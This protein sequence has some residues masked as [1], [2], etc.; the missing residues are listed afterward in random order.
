MTWS[1]VST[2]VLPSARPRLRSRL[3]WRLRRGGCRGPRRRR[4]RSAP[5]PG[6]SCAPW[7]GLAS[8]GLAALPVRLA[9]LLRSCSVRPVLAVLPLLPV[10]LTVL[11]GPLAGGRAAAVLTGCRSV[12]VELLGPVASR[13]RVLGSAVLLGA[14]RA[15]GTAVRLAPSRGVGTACSVALS[16]WSCELTPRGRR[17]RPTRPRARTR[18]AALR[19]GGRRGARGAADLARLDGLDEIALAHLRRALDAHGRGDALE[20]V[21]LHGG[22]A[23]AAGWALV[24]SDTKDP[25]P[26]S[27]AARRTGVGGEP[28]VWRH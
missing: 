3:R 28:T 26:S 2:P 27:R 25:S 23:R 7:R 22:Q 5:P 21:Q 6:C 9:V 4:R 10:L 14:A 17:R 13:R 11:L 18:S 15:A 12:A 19:L 16:A 8:R 24:V 1:S 20:L